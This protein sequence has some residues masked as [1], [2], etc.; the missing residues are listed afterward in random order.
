MEKEKKKWVFSGSKWEGIVGYSRGISVGNRIEIAGTTAVD[1]N[2]EVV[3]IGD[4]YAQTVFIIKKVEKALNELDATLEDVIRTRIFTTDISQWEEIGRAH[5]EYF[6]DI[7]PVSTMVEVSK[8]IDQDIQVEIEFT[9][10]KS[11]K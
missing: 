7:K 8:L 9:A 4:V 10:M 2:N 3:G 6:R 1:E 11:K 5:G